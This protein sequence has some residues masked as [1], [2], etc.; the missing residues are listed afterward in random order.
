MNRVTTVLAE[1]DA[2]IAARGPDGLAASKDEEVA[3]L[4]ADLAQA[5]NSAWTRAGH[6]GR[7]PARRQHAATNQTRRPPA[8][9]SCL[10]PGPA[11]RE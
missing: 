6:R 1:W 9:R 10:C 4:R 8:V 5:C 11:N 3:K 2:R 7:C